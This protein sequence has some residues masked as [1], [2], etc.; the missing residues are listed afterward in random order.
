MMMVADQYIIG[1]KLFL[2]MVHNLA[3]TSWLNFSETN[4]ST[5]YDIVAI[6]GLGG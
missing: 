6:W 3:R 1:Y 2:K 4:A 5:G